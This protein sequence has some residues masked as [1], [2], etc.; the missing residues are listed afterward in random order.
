MKQTLGILLTVAFL[1]GCASRCETHTLIE[2]SEEKNNTFSKSS[3]PTHIKRC[4]ADA[5]L[6]LGGS[7]T[8]RLADGTRFDPSDVDIAFIDTGIEDHPDLNVQ[9]G[10]R[11]YRR[12]KRIIEDTSYVNGDANGHGTTTAGVAAARDDGINFEGKQVVGVVPG[13]R[14]WPVRVRDTW[15]PA[16][17]GLVIAGLDWVTARAHIIE[18][19]SMSTGTLPSQAV[20]D[21]VARAVDAGIVVVCASGNSREDATVYSPSTEP[22]AISVGM[23]TDTDGLPGGFGPPGSNHGKEH[24]L[25]EGLVNNLDDTRTWSCNYGDVIEVLAP[26]HMILTTYLGG[27]YVSHSGTSQSTPYVAGAVALLI[28]S[29]PGHTWTPAEVALHLRNTGW[30]ESDTVA[31]GY[32]SPQVPPLPIV[33]PEALINVD[34]LIN[35]PFVP[36]TLAAIDVAPE[37]AS[38]A[39]GESA[40]IALYAWELPMTNLLLEKGADTAAPHLAAYTGNLRGIKRLLEKDGPVES[41]KGLTLLHAAAA[42]GHAA[43][44]EFLIAKGFDVTA[45][46]EN[47]ATPLYYAALGNHPKVAEILLAN[48]ADVNMKSEDGL[49]P[50][51][52]SAKHGD[53]D[54]VALLIENGADV[55][56]KNENG[57]IPLH[58]AAGEGHINS[59][60]LLIANGANV[61]A[62]D[63]YDETPLNWAAYEGH[64]DVVVLLLAK[65]ADVNTRSKWGWT[66]LH[67]AC[68]NNHK[69]TAELLLAKGTDVNARDE[70]GKTPLAVAAAHGHKEVSELLIAKGAK[71]NATSGELYAY[72]WN[73]T[74]GNWSPLHAACFSGNEEVAKLLLGHGAAVNAK[75]RNSFTPLDLARKRGHQEVAEML[76]NHGA[77]EGIPVGDRFRNARSLSSGTWL[78]GSFQYRTDEEWFVIDVEDNRS[79]LI[80]YDDSFGVGKYSAGIETYFYDQIV[81]DLPSKHFLFIDRRYID[82]KPIKFTPDYNGRLYLRLISVKPG[83]TTFAI[84][85]ET[86]E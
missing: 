16:D 42:G 33:H 31:G 36:A 64:T 10:V 28:A 15:G 54:T 70:A 32:V 57:G 72:A 4:K 80:Q 77:K 40:L 63:N 7:G 50:L 30:H 66:P 61:N 3:L 84:K 53:T 45:T 23:I 51:H 34:A 46:T 67:A 2:G 43:V 26:G 37:T 35:T 85:C 24:R 49:T 38:I 29:N 39:F 68:G 86:K 13:A 1:S 8:A 71:V 59:V 6:D 21:A 47:D 69:D 25:L 52:R 58:V 76:L 60:K 12:G 11:F 83:N 56:S 78:E 20:N 74:D 62:K 22:K 19:L 65:G 18:V 48:G 27:G 14:V 79:Y 73:M 17:E 5:V 9:D 75:T 55:N 81:D 41:L 82:Q 44:V